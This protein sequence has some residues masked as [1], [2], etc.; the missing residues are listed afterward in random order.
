L[1]PRDLLNTARILLLSVPKK[2]AEANLRRAISSAYYAVFHCLAK[3]CADLL[4][5]GNNAQRSKPAWAQVYR[6]LEHN[7]IKNMCGKSE[8]IKKVSE[9][10]RR[11]C[12][13]ICNSSYKKT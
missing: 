1:Q 4:I 9:R 2:P 6:A 12:Q 5:G 8:K 7:N 13:L 11:F 10:N 3:N